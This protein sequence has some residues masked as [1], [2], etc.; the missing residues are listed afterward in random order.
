MQQSSVVLVWLLSR[1]TDGVPNKNLNPL[2]EISDWPLS[3]VCE[4]RIDAEILY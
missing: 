2:T 1:K 3:G 4:N